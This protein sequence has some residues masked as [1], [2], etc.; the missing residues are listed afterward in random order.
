MFHFVEYII[1]YVIIDF[2]LLR[3]KIIVPYLLFRSFFL[4]FDYKYFCLCYTIFDKNYT[5]WK[6]I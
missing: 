4:N 5:K 1:V 3:L 2:L 6:Y